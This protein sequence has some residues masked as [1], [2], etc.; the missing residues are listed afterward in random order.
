[1]PSGPP[2]S[3]ESLFGDNSLLPQTRV[4]RK[5]LRPFEI[6]SLHDDIV[7]QIFIQANTGYLFQSALTTRLLPTL[8]GSSL[9]NMAPIRVGMFGAM[10]LHRHSSCRSLLAIS[11]IEPPLIRAR[12]RAVDLS[13][14]TRNRM[15]ILKKAKIKAD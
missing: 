9:Q 15:T 13:R 11:L 2:P 4:R 14:S 1:M 10:D 12:I 3:Y 7:G 8:D 6:R 5:S